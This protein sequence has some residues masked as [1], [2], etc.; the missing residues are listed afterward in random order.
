MIYTK[1][2]LRNW[3][4]APA[5]CNEIDLSTCTQ[6]FINTHTLTDKMEIQYMARKW[7]AAEWIVI[8][9]FVLLF[10]VFLY[11]KGGEE[12]F[13]RIINGYYGILLIFVVFLYYKI[14]LWSAVPLYVVAVAS[15]AR[16]V[17]NNPEVT[18]VFLQDGALHVVSLYT[19]AALLITIYRVLNIPQIMITDS[20]LVLN[21]GKTRIDWNNISEIRLKDGYFEVEKST[22]TLSSGYVGLG[23]IENRGNLINTLTKYCH[24]RDIP[25]NTTN[26]PDSTNVMLSWIRFP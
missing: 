13:F 3:R 10:L 23:S 12:P 15:L 8:L 5:R 14:G 6:T 19:A 24:E 25:F 22:F 9:A 17:F 21:H 2:L 7:A 1:R 20:Q 11:V 4:N 26:P 16:G 18:E